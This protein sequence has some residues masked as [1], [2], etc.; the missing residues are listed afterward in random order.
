MRIK[1]VVTLKEVAIDL[2]D[3]KAFY[4]Q[5]ETGVGDYFWDSL[6]A[7]I[8]SLRIYAGIHNRSYGLY[9]MLAR[10]FSYAIYYEIGDEIAY[11][12][13]VLP[14]RRDPVWIKKKLEERS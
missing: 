4:D 7:D 3:G 11:I 6:V 12:V 8:E 13:A 14:M 1:D 10:R 5:R 2:N 9:R